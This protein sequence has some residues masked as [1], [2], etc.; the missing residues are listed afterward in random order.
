MKEAAGVPSSAHPLDPRSMVM[1]A[2]IGPNPRSIRKEGDDH[3][4]VGDQILAIPAVQRVGLPRRVEGVMAEDHHVGLRSPVDLPCQKPHGLGRN[5]STRRPDKGCVNADHPDV[6]HPDREVVGPGTDPSPRDGSREGV[7]VEAPGAEGS[8]FV[9]AEL[10]KPPVLEGR[11][12]F[13]KG[14]EVTFAVTAVIDVVAAEQHRVHAGFAHLKYE[15][16]KHVYTSVL[17]SRGGATPASNM[18]IC[19]VRE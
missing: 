1:T 17:E 12:H 18:S 9:I 19:Y 10:G 13:E 14:F 7:L 6:S 3:V 4:A 5:K 15:V 2:Q 11:Y 8:G 16:A